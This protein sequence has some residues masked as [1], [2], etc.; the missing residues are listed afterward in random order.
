MVV[1]LN[2]S[3]EESVLSE[4]VPPVNAVLNSISSFAPNIKEKTRILIA[5]FLSSFKLIF[6]GFP[7]LSWPSTGRG[8]AAVPPDWGT[9]VAKESTVIYGSRIHAHLCEYE[10]ASRKLKSLWG[11][12]RV[13]Q[14]R[15]D[16]ASSSKKPELSAAVRRIKK[17][18]Q[19]VENR[20]CTI[21]AGSGPFREKLEN[22]DRFRAMAGGSLEGS[23]SSSQVVAVEDEE[24]EDCEEE[25]APYPPS[26][27]LRPP[28]WGEACGS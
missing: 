12:L 2:F 11:E 23:R 3:D 9:K 25:V 5:S 24:E 15:S 18:I 28:G 19:E 4:P 17:A 20:R 14:E 26:G 21:L 13:A 7:H 10:D 16:R 6:N 27:G 1:D 8:A 22:D